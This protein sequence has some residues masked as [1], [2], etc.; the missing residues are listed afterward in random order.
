MTNVLFY[1]T[2]YE[3]YIKF[4]F[5]IV[6]YL[7]MFWLFENSHSFSQ[8]VFIIKFKYKDKIFMD[9]I[10]IIHRIQEN[11]LLSDKNNININRSLFCLHIL[12]H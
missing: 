4:R 9:E 5:N 10:R 11:M 2:I 7:K 6:C 3:L 8:L 1:C 12:A